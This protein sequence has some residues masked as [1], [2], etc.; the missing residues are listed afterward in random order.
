MTARGYAQSFMSAL[1][2]AENLTKTFG[3]FTAVSDVSLTVEPGE[4]LGFLGPNGA[5]KTTTMKMLT[6]FLAPTS[7]RAEVDGHSVTSG[8]VAARRRIGYLPEGAPLY[9]E[10]TTG[11]FLA[12]IA[13]AHGFT[14][15]EA[16]H[17]VT[18]IAA[19]ID[20]L[21][22]MRQ[23]IDTLSKG[24]RRRVGLAAAI[25]HA[26]DVL[27]LDEPT[28]GLDPNQKHQ[29]RRLIRAMSAD[30][31]IIISTHVLEEVEALCSRAIVI[32]QGRIVA[33][34]TPAELKSRSRYY[35]AVTL[36]VAP[37]EVADIER[38]ARASGL[39][40]ALE[41]HREGNRVVLTLRPASGYDIAAAVGEAATSGGWAI[42][43]FSV[44]SGRL[45]DVF[46]TL[47]RGVSS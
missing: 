20:V 40:R 11:S 3:H 1:L 34:G 2:K 39:I 28:D 19:V 8:A 4:V 10:M 21:D 15:Q 18:E 31:A 44:E 26:P 6:G 30:R 9:G 7:G 27:I 46:R 23:R 25:L 36:V 22:V 41:S 37:S 29:V 14:G 24:Y 42:E 35:G 5:G 33:D 16:R 43:Q 12:F 17:R 45:D 47:T 38:F 13:A 32:N